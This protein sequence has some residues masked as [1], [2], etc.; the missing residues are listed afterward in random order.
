MEP[1]TAIWHFG[2]YVVDERKNLALYLEQKVHLLPLYTTD[3]GGTVFID[4]DTWPGT[5]GVQGIT[6]QQIAEAK[7]S[8][9]KPRGGAGWGYMAGPDGA[10]I[11]YQGDMPTERFNHVHMYQE[12]PICAELWY[13]KHLNAVLPQRAGQ[14]AHTEADCKTDR[15]EDTWP[16]LEKEGTIRRP[17]GVVSF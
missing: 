5:D 2:W 11:E 16:A 17:S 1:Q 3:E 9:V 7:A 13:A 10:I 15:G 6:K 8:G 4:S 12:D 14:A